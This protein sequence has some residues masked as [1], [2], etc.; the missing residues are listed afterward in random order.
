[1]LELT[2]PHMAPATKGVANA[3]RAVLYQCGG[4]NANSTPRPDLL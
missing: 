2:L 4:D 3:Q 1:M